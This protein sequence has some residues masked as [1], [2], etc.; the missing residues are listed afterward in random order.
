M[1]SI[2]FSSI[3][4]SDDLEDLQYLAMS[5]DIQQGIKT[6]NKQYA[7]YY[8]NVGDGIGLRLSGTIDDYG[9]FTPDYI[10]PCANSDIEECIKYYNVYLRNDTPMVVYSDAVSDNEMAF[11]LQ[12]TIKYNGCEKH[13]CDIGANP[14]K[15]K[16]V[17]VAG[18]SIWGTVIFPTA[19]TKEATY[20]TEDIYYS[21][22]VLRSKEGEH[23]A[24]TTYNQ[25]SQNI[26]R[27]RL[28]QEDLL[29]VVDSYFLPKDYEKDF[30]YDILGQI[31]KSL[32]ITNNETNE[33]VYKLTINAAGVRLQIF[34]NK[35]DLIGL[36]LEGMR[37][38]G[39][40]ILQGNVLF[41]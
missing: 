19:K 23:K 10:F 27:A 34:I 35:Y 24:A 14:S 2:G 12:N 33:E 13:F 22:L 18:L 11:V 9:K 5:C 16:I 26:I 37:F 25:K 30:S 21:N 8:K 4:D 40:C 7:Q 28:E 41:E 1:R 6:K 3:E 15:N 32:L 31:Q 38:M 29:S 39:N 36:P 17:Q 20:Q